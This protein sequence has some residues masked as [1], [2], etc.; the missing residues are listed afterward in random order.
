MALISPSLVVC[1]MSDPVSTSMDADERDR[2]LGTGGTGVIS[3]PNS[4]DEAPHS[5]PLSYGYDRQESSFYF[6]L[7][8]DPES[9]KRELVGRPVTFV[10]Y[11]QQD[12][13]WR[14]VIN[15]GTLEETTKESIATETLEGLQHVHIPLVDIF[16]QPIKDVQFE[17]FRLVPDEMTTRK[18]SRTGV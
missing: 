14:S 1:I 7:A 15:K 10:V 9:E 8:V 17:F 3:F 2:F 11:G 4:A 16:G 12:E 5:V 6:R 13:N 18:E